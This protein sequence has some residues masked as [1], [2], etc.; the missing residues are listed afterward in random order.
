MR[1]SL[2]DGCACC[3]SPDR[4]REASAASEAVRR[5]LG[6]AVTPVG[7]CAA[8][9]VRS[10][11][12]MDLLAAA[13]ACL[14]APVGGTGRQPPRASEGCSRAA[15]RREPAA[16]H[17]LR[18]RSAAGGAQGAPDAA[19]GASAGPIPTQ[20]LSR[21]CPPASWGGGIYPGPIYQKSQMAQLEIFW[22]YIIIDN[23]NLRPHCS[24]PFHSNP[25]RTHDHIHRP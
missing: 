11:R 8:R 3:C 7:G 19:R 1:L 12:C 10:A 13:M 6:A 25:T 23:N 2:C 21:T 20:D 24:Q 17:Q 18:G 16:R 9:G 22:V 15:R 4:L 14:A 5:A